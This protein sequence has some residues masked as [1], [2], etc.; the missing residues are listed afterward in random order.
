[1]KRISEIVII[2]GKGGT[3]K[4]TVT[5]SLAAVIPS[6]IIVDTDVD[7][8]NLHLLLKPQPIERRDFIGKPVAVINPDQCTSCNR[9]RELCRFEAI[10]ILHKQYTVEPFSCEGCGLC[11]RAC[12][13]GAVTMRE[14]I[15]GQWFLSQT[16]MGNMVHARLRPGAEN[17]GSLVAMV[18]RQA[19]LRAKEKK[20][21][22]ILIDGPPGIG[23]P[24]IAAVSGTNLAIIVTE[25]TYSGIHDMERIFTLLKHF[26]IKTGIV[27]NRF[28]INEKNAQKIRSFARANGIKVFAEIPHSLCIINEISAGRLPSLWC[29]PLAEAT[30]TIYDALKQELQM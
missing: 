22:T 26:G 9:C 12:P 10:D 23:C 1:M 16:D 4:T 3:G 8:A 28:D 13:A 11:S 18:R 5:A 25:P 24:V 29:R 6:K 27:I 7:A 21:D 14:R 20:A 2:S 19:Q 17:S 15:V 30:G